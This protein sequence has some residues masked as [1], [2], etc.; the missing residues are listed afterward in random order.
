MILVLVGVDGSGP[1]VGV[2]ASVS[3]TRDLVASMFHD[4]TL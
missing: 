2:A 4:E 1:K 3:H